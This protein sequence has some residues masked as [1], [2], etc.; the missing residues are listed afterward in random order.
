MGSLPKCWICKDQG[1]VFFN[2]K[3]AGRM[4]EKVLRCSCIKGQ[5]T[6]ERV[7]VISYD[8]AERVDKDNL[9][10]FHER[11]PELAI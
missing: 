3:V 4:Y 9:M 11:F 2:M 7:A 10:K 8:F 5:D 6:S 1:L